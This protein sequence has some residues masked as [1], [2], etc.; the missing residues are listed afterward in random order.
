[1]PKGQ[2]IQGRTKEE[3][4]RAQE[5]YRK[6]IKRAKQRR[7]RRQAINR[8]IWQELCSGLP[9]M[10]EEAMSLTQPANPG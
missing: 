6:D 8:Q 4:I 9:E 10:A 7:R 5:Q 1:M 2:E 3:K